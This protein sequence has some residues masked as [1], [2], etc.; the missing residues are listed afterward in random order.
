MLAREVE[1]ID[2]G[3]VHGF[4]WPQMASEYSTL[5]KSERLAGAEAILATGKR[6]RPAMVI[7]VQAPDVQTAVEYARHAEKLGADAIISLPPA[8]PDN[9]DAMLAYYKEVG[10]ATELPLI[11][12]TTRNMSVALLVRMFKEIPTLR[13]VKDEAGWISAGA[14]RPASGANLGQAQG[15]HGQSRPNPD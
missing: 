1:F 14:H 4:V 6:L 11:V 13:Y 7:G 9:D 3:G 15:V 12:Q 8:P 2:R 5:S 10:K